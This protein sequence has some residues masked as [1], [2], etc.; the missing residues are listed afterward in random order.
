MLEIKTSRHAVIGKTLNI[1]V[2]LFLS[3]IYERAFWSVSCFGYQKIPLFIVDTL[4]ILLAPISFTDPYL[5]L[6]LQGFEDV[7]SS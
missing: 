6:S 3:L 5:F 1:K 7:S 2:G 4:K